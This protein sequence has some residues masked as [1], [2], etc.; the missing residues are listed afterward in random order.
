M[1]LGQDW[2]AVAG[3]SEPLPP[4][5]SQ[6]RPLGK[7]HRAGARIAWVASLTDAS[8]EVAR[9]SFKGPFKWP[10]CFQNVYSEYCAGTIRSCALGASSS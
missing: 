2:P 10:W 3:Q 8:R 9:T 1:A 7:E 6:N 5:N 4:T